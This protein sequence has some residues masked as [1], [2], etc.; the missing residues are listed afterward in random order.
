MAAKQF[1]YGVK[2]KVI[3]KAENREEA[4]KKVV[5]KLQHHSWLTFDNE[6]AGQ[7]VGDFED[8]PD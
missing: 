3:V 2:G 7:I 1:I 6:N 5:E 8:I 4:R